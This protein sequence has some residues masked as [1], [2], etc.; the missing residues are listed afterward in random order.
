MVGYI[1]RSTGTIKVPLLVP[2][3]EIGGSAL[4]DQCIIR[5]DT[6]RQVLYQHEQFRT[7]VF[8]TDS[9]Q[10]ETPALGSVDRPSRA[11]AVSRKTASA[12]LYGLYA[13]QALYAGGMG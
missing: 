3:G 9:W 11:G 7:G 6:P 12:T 1:G 2:P 8:C 5:I 10:A 4:L 13:K